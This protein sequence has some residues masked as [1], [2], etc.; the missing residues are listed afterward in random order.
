ML[1]ILPSLHAPTPEA[2]DRR[3]HVVLLAPSHAARM[4]FPRTCQGGACL[5]HERAIIQTERIVMLRAIAF[6]Q[7][8]GPICLRHCWSLQRA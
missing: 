4:Q 5:V 1:S 7:E 8:Q 3:F 6:K 2:L